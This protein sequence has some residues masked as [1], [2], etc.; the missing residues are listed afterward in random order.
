MHRGIFVLHYE[1]LDQLMIKY[2]IPL[3]NAIDLRKFFRKKSIRYKW[4][5]KQINCGINPLQKLE[6]IKN[7]DVKKVALIKE[8]M[9]AAYENP[10]D[11][12]YK[13][14]PPQLYDVINTRFFY[15]NPKKIERA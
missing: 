9:R 7:Y 13:E 4:K 3:I 11:I 1:A 8:V 5:Y 15:Y 2:A 6:S 10:L 14:A 12:E